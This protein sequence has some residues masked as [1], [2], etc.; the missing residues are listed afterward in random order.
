MTS[1]FLSCGSP[2]FNLREIGDTILVLDTGNW[3][4]I[5]DTILVFMWFLLRPSDLLGQQISAYQKLGT[6]PGTV[7][8]FGIVTNR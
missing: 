3:N 1:L 8:Y 6:K 5:G 2:S 7:T 4:E